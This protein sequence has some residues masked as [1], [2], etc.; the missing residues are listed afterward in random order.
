M[1]ESQAAGGKSGICKHGPDAG[2][3]GSYGIS[4]SS[5]RQL[6]KR[7]ERLND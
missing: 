4:A 7:K 1:E 6:R 5:A 3:S 2:T